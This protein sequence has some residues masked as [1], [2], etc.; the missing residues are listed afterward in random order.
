MLGSS[1]RRFT[2]NVKTCNHRTVPVCP[3]WA[4]ARRGR[5]LNFIWLNILKNTQALGFS[6]LICFDRRAF[7]H[8]GIEPERLRS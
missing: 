3:I 4:K 1:S 5:S 7:L 6:G 2:V 8:F